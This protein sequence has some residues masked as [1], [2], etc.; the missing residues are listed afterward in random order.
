MTKK[1]KSIAFLMGSMSLIL[2]VC[3]LLFTIFNRSLLVNIPF[4]QH[5]NIFAIGIRYDI[6]I[7]FLVNIP[8]VISLLLPLEKLHKK[9]SYMLRLLLFVLTNGFVVIAN[10]VDIFYFPFT[11]KR[12]TISI[13]P[14][15]K[16]QANMSS[17]GIEFLITYWYAFVLLTLLIFSLIKLLGHA[18]SKMEDEIERPKGNWGIPLIILTLVWVIGIKSTLNIFGKG[19]EIVSSVE[20][21]K[22]PIASSVA[23]NS[24]FTLI[25]SAS[26]PYI[27]I[28]NIPI[29]KTT[30][31]APSLSKSL[32]KENQKNVV[33]II[34]ESFTA[35]ASKL[36]NPEICGNG[37]TPFLDSLMQNSFYYTK[38]SANGRKS[39]DAV[40]SIFL[41]IPGTQTPYILSKENKTKLSLPSCLAQLGYNTSFFHGSHNTTM[42]FKTFCQKNGIKHYYG[43]DEYPYQG[44]FDG[45]WGIWDEPYLQY[46][47]DKLDVSPKPF[48]SSVFTLSSHNPFVVPTKYKGRFP[49]GDH[50]IEETIGYA[51]HALRHFFTHIKD[52]EWYNNTLFIITADH[53]IMPWSN[54]YATNEK[55]FHIPLIFFDPGASLKGKSDD[56]AQQI[57]IFP[58]TMS[59]LN[60]PLKVQLPGQDLF[61]DNKKKFTVSIINESFQFIMGDI[62]YHYLDNEC[63]G[64][65]NIKEDP[66]EQIN[67]KK[68]QHQYLSDMIL[69]QTW[70]H[71]YCQKK[72]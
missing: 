14:Y 3:R 13:F 21:I 52:K 54:K 26:T 23:L 47:T 37:Y 53:A 39:M 28:N 30:T 70:I 25:K 34:L 49:K 24:A 41:S 68:N 22:N 4:N 58:T 10:L 19:I 57:D 44:D 32:K 29:D 40:P 12:I 62:L 64:I 69:I 72:I 31:P 36:L 2:F 8:F 11:L 59:Y 5:I 20:K 67:L 43:L 55:A 45:T 66:L 9:G 27:H 16:T 15:L 50:G 61:R 38:A 48:F 51:D 33:I 46:V 7:L 1:I 18:L 63:I 35:E 6:S 56:R 65:Y 42:G 60:H 17:L 71:D